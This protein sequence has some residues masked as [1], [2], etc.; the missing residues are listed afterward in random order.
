MKQRITSR[1]DF[2]SL[3][4]LR[5]C[6]RRDDVTWIETI[7]GYFIGPIGVL[8]FNA[9]ILNYINVYFTDVLGLSGAFLVVFPM[10]S[11]ALAV[12]VNIGMGL[13]IDRTHTA[14][15]KARPYILISVPMLLVSGVVMFTL[16][17]SMPSGV[18]QMVWIVVAYNLYLS[19]ANTVYSMGHSLMVPLSTRDPGKR[20]QLS[21]WVNT[22]ASGAVGAASIVFPVILSF[23]GVSK[24]R[25]TAVMCVFAGIAAAAAVLEYYFTRERIT[26]ETMGDAGCGAVDEASR[27]DAAMASTVDGKPITVGRQV[28]AMLT[29]P[30]WWMIIGFYVLWQFSGNMKNGSMT[31]FC[32]YVVG[33]YSDGSTQSILAIIGAI[34]M[35][36]GIVVATPISNRIGK[37]RFLLIGLA[38]GVVG[39]VIMWINPTN[40]MTVSAGLIVKALGMI[41]GMTIM[42]AL[43][44][45]VLD[46]ME[47]K[48]G[49]RCDGL[50]MSIYSACMTALGGVCSGVLNAILSGSGYVAPGADVS[51]LDVTV[52]KTLADGTLVYNQPA[53]AQF[54]IEACYILFELVSWAIIFIIM[55]GLRVEKNLPAEQEEIR[56]RRAM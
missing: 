32:N 42:T 56:R 26:E 7:V 45:D 14:A 15:G 35:A 16:P 17:V 28:K 54:A 10:A 12:V 38:V 49:F 18:A 4:V 43:F 25:W 48:N 20:N 39:G 30:Y 53:S 33:T 9:I 40:M 3:P 23:L 52:Q 19:I 6:I 55:L 11:S 36:A 8:L 41:P 13:L 5:S 24:T 46:H 51:G 21:V 44:S 2:W 34:P 47:W 27:S 22:A 31:Y 29:E 1:G 37:Q 50:S